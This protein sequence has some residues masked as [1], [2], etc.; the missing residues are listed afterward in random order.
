MMDKFFISHYNGD[1]DIADVLSEMLRRITLNQIQP[2]FS[3]D[4]SEI[5]GFKP[6]DMWFGKIL[7]RISQSRAVVTIITPNSINRPWIYYESGMAQSLDNCEVIPI[8]V[9]IKRDTLSAPLNMYQCYQISDYRSLKEFTSKLLSKFQIPFDEEM[10]KSILERSVTDISKKTF[11]EQ[12]KELPMSMKDILNE[13]RMHF[14]SSLSTIF[15]NN[16]NRIEEKRSKENKYEVSESILSYS[17]NLKIDFPEGERVVYIEIR[18]EDTFQYT[19]NQIF[20]S[21][22]NRVRFYSYMI[23]WI[24]IEEITGKKIIIREISDRIYASQIFKRNSSYIIKFTTSPYS[25]LDS[26][27]DSN[28]DSSNVTDLL[29]DALEKPEE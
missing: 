15:G 25:G 21:L 12:D 23:E 4:S 17:I 10:A 6:G 19:L 1:R 3:S 5:G 22:E 28:H 13:V 29:I 11:G 16:T 27:T 14:D 8:C 2:W 26:A 24:I 7:E 20:F 9:G 18:K